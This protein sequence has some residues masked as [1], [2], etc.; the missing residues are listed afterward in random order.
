MGQKTLMPWQSW[1]GIMCG[2]FLWNL[3]TTWR[4]SCAMCL[5]QMCLSSSALVLAMLFWGRCCL[6]CGLW[7]YADK[8][9]KVEVSICDSSF[10][11]KFSWIQQTIAFMAKVCTSR[12]Q[13]DLC[14]K[15]LQLWTKEQRLVPGFEALPKPRHLVQ[16]EQRRGRNNAGGGGGGRNPAG[17]TGRNPTTPAGSS[18]NGNTPAPAPSPSPSPSPGAPAGGVPPGAPIPGRSLLSSFGQVNLWSGYRTGVSIK[19]CFWLTVCK[20]SKHRPAK[21]Q[22]GCCSCCCSCDCCCCCCCRWWV[23][24]GWDW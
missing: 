7:Q 12:A 18:T 20:G 1:A 15:N 3:T 10:V 6:T 17:G 9:I 2:L 14:Y 13:K 24:L 23:A 19:F 8:F 5:M 16:W 22:K 4:K 21:I 11:F